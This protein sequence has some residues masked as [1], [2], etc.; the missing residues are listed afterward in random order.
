MADGVVGVAPLLLGVVPFGLIFGVAA[1]ASVVG[2]TIGYATS[3]IIFGGS[4][5][6]ATIELFNAGAAGFVIVATGLVLNALHLMYSAALAPAFA[7]FSRPQRI[8]LPY[9]L[10]D[11]AFAVSI[12]RFHDEQDPRYRRLFFLGAGSG[13]WLTWQ[14]STGV[15]VLFGAIIPA[16]W[17][18]DFAIPLVFLALLVPTLSDRPALIAALVGGGVAVA[19]SAAPFHTGLMIGALCGVVAGVVAERATR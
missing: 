11:Q 10:T 15:G 4:A 16:T 6:L 7:E 12:V 17:S 5:Q 19:A 18:L 8:L 1:A 2:G 9:L 14:L 13:L 3:L